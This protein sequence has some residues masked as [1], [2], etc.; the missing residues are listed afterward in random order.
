MRK[1]IV[2]IS[3]EALLWATHAREAI[4]ALTQSDT[5]R[6]RPNICCQMVMQNQRRTDVK[7]V[8]WN[9]WLVGSVCS[10]TYARRIYWKDAPNSLQNVIVSFIISKPYWERKDNDVRCLPVCFKLKLHKNHLIHTIFQGK[11]SLETEMYQHL[12]NATSSIGTTCPNMICIVCACVGCFLLTHLQTDSSNSHRI[13]FK[14]GKS[15]R[16][17]MNPFN[18]EIVCAFNAKTMTNQFY[19]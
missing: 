4:F 19:K 7:W 3:F 6:E 9:F 14:W 5:H 12:W 10:R 2:I 11:F 18:M 13:C 15:E 16:W 17:M 8:L 1:S